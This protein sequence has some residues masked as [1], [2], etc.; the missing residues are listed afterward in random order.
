MKLIIELSPTQIAHHVDQLAATISDF[1]RPMLYI[2][3][4]GGFIFGADLCR[5]CVSAEGVYLLDIERGYGFGELK[6]PELKDE[7][8]AFFLGRTH[9]F[10]DVVT[11]TGTTFEYLKSL[12]PERQKDNAV[13]CALVVKGSEYTPTLF[14]VRSL[15]EDFLTGYGMGPRRNLPYIAR[16]EGVWKEE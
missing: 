7:K 10:I 3:Q 15:T 5:S 4:D 12:V 16:M 14:G 9:V 8:P 6:E 11:E 1:E 2:I 13:T